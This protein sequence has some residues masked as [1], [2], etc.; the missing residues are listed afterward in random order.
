[1]RVE[2]GIITCDRYIHLA[3]L[4]SSIINQDYEDWDMTIV[5]DSP[6]PMDLRDNQALIGFLRLLNEKGHDWRV[7]YG[8]HKGSH[9]CHQMV[10]E[11]SRHPLTFRCDD[12]HYLDRKFLSELVFPH[13]SDEKV[14]ATG[15]IV[16]L[17]NDPHRI[18]LP[19][20]WKE[21]ENYTEK[22]NIRKDGAI[23]FGNNLQYVLHKDTF[24]KPVQHLIGAMVYRTEPARKWGYNL[25]LSYVSMCED[26]DFSYQFYINGWKLFVVPT[27][28]YWHFPEKTHGWIV[29]KSEEYNELS[30]KDRMLF[31]TRVRN[32][33]NWK[34]GMII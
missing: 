19:D 3:G 17:P 28:M 10:L 20:N 13:L 21:R 11:T 15:G 2:I 18:Y 9:F 4:L 31:E 16:L 5:D 29:K 7:L 12:D 8:P 33:N 30:K 23:G 27:A 32:W 14:G 22:V 25:D 24:P 34:P 1:M 26:D 6:N